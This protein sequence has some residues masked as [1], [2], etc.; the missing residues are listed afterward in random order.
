HTNLSNLY[1]N[2]EDWSL[3]ESHAE[4]SLHIRDSLG[5]SPSAITLNNLVYAQVKLKKTEQGT[6]N[7]QTA[8]QWA[9]PFERVQLLDNLQEVCTQTGN[10]QQASQY[11]SQLLQLKDSL[12][13]LNL[14][15]KIA[16][17]N[18][19]YETAEKQQQ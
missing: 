8:L 2:L 3:A 11:L 1:I 18:A 12:Y 19:V 15:E 9:T 7:Y 4:R 17:I 6:Q 5:A 16:T 10:F 14:D 13:Q